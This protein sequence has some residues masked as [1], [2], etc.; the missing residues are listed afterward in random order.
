MD[1]P[2]IL[3]FGFSK[4]N[5]GVSISFFELHEMIPFEVKRVYTISTS[6]IESTRGNHAHVNQN[7]VIICVEGCATAKIISKSGEVLN[8]DVTK[9]ALFIP[10]NQWIEINMYPHSTLL[11]FASENYDNLISIFEKNK[12]LNQD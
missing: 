11:C 7:Q 5:N 9:Q 6:A 8:F 4:M 2:K 3:E 1:T 12:F 10:K